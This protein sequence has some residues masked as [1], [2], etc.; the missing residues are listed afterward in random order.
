VDARLSD[1]R[2]AYYAENYPRLQR[3]KRCYDP[4]GFFRFPQA[5]GA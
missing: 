3:V 1:W 2:T 5:V 4:S